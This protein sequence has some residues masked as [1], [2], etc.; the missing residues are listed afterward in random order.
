MRRAQNAI[1]LFS[2][3]PPPLS[4]SASYSYYSPYLI[5]R[6][7]FLLAL[8]ILLLFRLFQN[9]V[10][11]YIKFEHSKLFAKLTLEFTK[12]AFLFFSFS[13]VSGYAPMLFWSAISPLIRLVFLFFTFATWHTAHAIKCYSCANDFI[14]W[15]SF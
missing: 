11:F 9:I 7:L 15:V 1:I 14:V 3:P 6:F 12:S 13:D 5:A 8:S 10:L 2:Q 4:P